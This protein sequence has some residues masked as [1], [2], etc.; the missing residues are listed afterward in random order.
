[1]PLQY[2]DGGSVEYHA[3]LYSITHR[4]VMWEN[5]RGTRGYLSEVEEG[6]FGYLIGIEIKILGIEI[7]DNVKFKKVD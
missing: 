4:H 5:I 2:K 6:A 7:Y 3:I 1:M